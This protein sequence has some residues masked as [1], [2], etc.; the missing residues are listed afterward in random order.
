MARGPGRH[1]LAAPDA[2]V[3]RERGLRGRGGARAP[4]EPPLW[5]AI[6]S[7]VAVE[8]PEANVAPVCLAGFTDSHWL[9]EAFDTVAYGFFPMGGVG[10]AGGPWALLSGGRGG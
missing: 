3:G 2:A 9:R 6:E 8:E 1:A 10:S 5:D 4:R 7:F